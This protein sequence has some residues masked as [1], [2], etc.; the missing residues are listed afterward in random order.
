M[1]QRVVCG[2]CGKPGFK[3]CGAHVEQVL[4]NVPPARRCRCHV[5]PDKGSGSREDEPGS[6]LDRIRKAL[7]E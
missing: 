3:G 2:R 4:G 5:R 7:G 6:W 1:C